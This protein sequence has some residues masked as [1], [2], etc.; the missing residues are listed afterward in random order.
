MPEYR[1]VLFPLPEDP[2]DRLTDQNLAPIG[3]AHDPCAHIYSIAGH[4]GPAVDVDY[5]VISVRIDAD[6]NLKT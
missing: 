2:E 1:N 3:F 5:Y 6:A 4:I